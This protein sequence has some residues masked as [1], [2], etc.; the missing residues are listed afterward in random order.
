MEMWHDKEIFQ[1]R[2]S[3]EISLLRLVNFYNTVKPH[4]GID[5]MTPYEKLLEYFYKQKL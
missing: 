2:K 1:D 5:D 3:R 4:K